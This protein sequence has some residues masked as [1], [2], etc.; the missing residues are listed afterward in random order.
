M[1]KAI[2]FV[3]LATLACSS[4]EI[5][6]EQFEL[7]NNSI[8]LPGTL[9]HPKLNKQ[10]P[11]IIFVHGS[12]AVDRNGNQGNLVK[13]NYIKALADSLNAR[14][15]AFYRYDKRTATPSNLRLMNS[16]D[17]RIA[18]F[19]KDLEVAIRV[20]ENDG[21]FSSLHLIGHSQGSLVAM[22]ARS[23]SIESYISLA[24]PGKTVDQTLIEQITKQDEE[25][26]KV[27]KMHLEELIKTDTIINVN[28]FLQSLFAPP[29]QKFLRDW[30]QY[31]PSEQ[32]KNL[33]I[34]TLV[35]VGDADLQ[36]TE[37]DAQALKQAKPDAQLSVISKMNHVLK[38]VSTFDENQKSYYNP[39][40]PLSTKMVDAIVEFI[41]KNE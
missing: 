5:V 7:Y 32:I 1:K 15:I 11:L 2:H 24:G 36:V 16:Q 10:L 26:G 39:N 8:Y 35:L 17:I 23:D 20:F 18:D 22:L 9:G 38:T 27:T 41:L 33:N 13:A 19:V 28:P 21:R 25:L 30:A 29:N 6:E 12:G 4:Q 37:E 40:F 34:P 31:D 3:L 14:Q